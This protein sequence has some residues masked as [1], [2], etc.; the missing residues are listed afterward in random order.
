VRHLRMLGAAL[1]AAAALVA[2]L[3]SSAFALAEPQPTWGKFRN[4]PTKGEYEGHPAFK[5]TVAA[6]TPHAGGD[7]RVG[8]ITVPVTKQIIL[9]GAYTR[10]KR[11]LFGRPEPRLAWFIPPEN[12]TPPISVSKETVPGEVL[13]NITEAEMNEADWPQAL[14]E[15]YKKAQRR[16]RF[17]EGQT[18]EIIETAGKDEDE[19]SEYNILAEEDET[20]IVANVQVTGKNKW[21]EELGGNC[22]IGSEADPIVQHL[23]TGTST[24]PLTGE[25]ITGTA[26]TAHLAYK[27]EEAYLTGVKLVDNTYPVPGVEGCGGPTYEQYLDPVV[28]HAFGLPAEAGASKT[29]LLGA[30]YV[31]QPT[32]VEQHGQ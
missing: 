7:Y 1:F 8:S 28:N 3:A 10:T 22:L 27:G 19:I 30:L 24:S 32:S 17:H 18:T 9:Q 5:C 11:E 15:S 2:V 21:L 31:A 14:R 26:G 16:H 29:E 4:C 25:E 23:T 12:G 6:T 13:G 20:G